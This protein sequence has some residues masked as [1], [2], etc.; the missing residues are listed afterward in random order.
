MA[1]ADQ[2]I[3]NWNWSKIEIP[4][5]WNYAWKWTLAGRRL[6]KKTNFLENVHGLDKLFVAGLPIGSNVPQH[7]ASIELAI[8]ETR[9]I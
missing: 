6:A 8:F 5:V 9:I 1:L 3:E 2:V 7:F 4:I